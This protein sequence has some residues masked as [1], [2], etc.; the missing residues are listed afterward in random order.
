MIPLTGWALCRSSTIEKSL[1]DYVA[2]Y[3]HRLED[4]LLPHPNEKVR[5]R[6]FSDRRRLDVLLLDREGLPVIVE[7]KRYQ[8]TV[9]DVRQLQR[10]LKRLRAETRKRLRG[11]LV[12]GGARK[13][14]SEVRRAARVK[15]VVELVQFRVDVEFSLS[16]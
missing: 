14:R 8:I 9:D 15:P 6:V 1:S 10:Y 2:A 13:L 11:I 16:H 4:G 3:P 5:E 7:C 12:H